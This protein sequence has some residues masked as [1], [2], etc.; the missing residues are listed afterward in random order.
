[1][2]CLRDKS[3]ATKETFHVQRRKITRFY[4]QLKARSPS[5]GFELSALSQ[6]KNVFTRRS[7]ASCD[8]P[9][10]SK[11]SSPHPLV[12]RNGSREYDYGYWSI[13]AR[14]ESRVEEITK[15]K[16]W[17]WWIGCAQGYYWQSSQGTVLIL[18]I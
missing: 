11:I 15:Q 6:F 14:K 2:F 1:M 17:P 3:G 8:T 9:K 5:R 4:E 10:I 7:H 18:L 13:G 16:R 12:A